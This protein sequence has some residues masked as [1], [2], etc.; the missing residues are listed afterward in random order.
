MLNLGRKP[1]EQIII[2]DDIVLTVVE[3]RGGR[4]KIG[5]DAPKEVRIRRGEVEP[6]DG[7]ETNASD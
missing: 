3:V 7:K 2:G 6:H 5:I 1:G 4:V